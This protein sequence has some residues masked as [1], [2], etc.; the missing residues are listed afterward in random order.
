MEKKVLATDYGTAWYYS[1][2]DCT[3]VELWVG[4]G[5]N[6]IDF[7]KVKPPGEW[8]LKKTK[9]SQEYIHPKGLR[10]RFEFRQ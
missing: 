10:L 3:V 2:G 9:V 8:D 1:S 7:A 5:S 6:K 4:E